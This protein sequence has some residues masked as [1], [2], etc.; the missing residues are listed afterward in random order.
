MRKLI[1]IIIVFA[2]ISYSYQSCASCTIQEYC[3]ND[4]CKACPEN[5]ANSDPT[6]ANTTTACTAAEWGTCPSG[7]PAGKW[8]AGIYS[9]AYCPAGTTSEET[10]VPT[11]GQWNPTSCINGQ[12]L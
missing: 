2:L 1:S 11:P 10:T 5:T 7:C 8:C 9:C 3:E 6:V 12:I 4:S